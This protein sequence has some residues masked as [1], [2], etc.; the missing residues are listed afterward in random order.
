[1]AG[2]I[3]MWFVSLRRLLLGVEAIASPGAASL[4]GG[5][6]SFDRVRSVG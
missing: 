6:R 4:A 1:M 5:M 2:S 3:L